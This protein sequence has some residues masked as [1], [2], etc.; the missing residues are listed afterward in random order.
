MSDI[1]LQKFSKYKK[2]YNHLLTGGTYSQELA[3]QIVQDEIALEVK[4]EM[5]NIILQD[6]LNI[7]KKLLGHFLKQE[8]KNKLGDTTYLYTEY[9]KLVLPNE[10]NIK[11]E[12]NKLLI[13]DID[14]ASEK[15]SQEI[16]ALGYKG[17]F[18]EFKTLGDVILKKIKIKKGIYNN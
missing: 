2:K 7:V 10:S 18:S 15:Y 6:Y 3:N 13:K 17:D 16:E 14:N 1:N 5:Q 9:L 11:D 8:D 4:R 12:V